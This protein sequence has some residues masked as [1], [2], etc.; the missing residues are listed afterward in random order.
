[1][2]TENQMQKV[3]G[4]DVYG[5]DGAKIG[6]AGTVY[7]DD[8][9]GRPEWVTVHTGLLGTKET[10]VPISEAEVRDNRVTVPYS[11]EQ[12]K[13]APSVDPDDGRH[14]SPK[15]EQRLYD[16]YGLRY[17]GRQTDTGR[18][19]GTVGRDTSGAETDEAMTRSEE[20]L[21]VGTRQ[22][23]AG[24]ARLRKYVV[25][26]EQNVQVPV[27]REEVR[28]ER[29]P[30]TDRNRGAA[31]NGPDISEEEHEV[32]LHEERP[33]VEK[34]AVPLERVRL[35]KE[36]VTRQETVR[37]EVRKEQIETEGLDENR[38]R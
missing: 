15:E 8:D 13:G 12:V 22:E 7:L 16:H 33:V 1:M 37:G 30:I 23:E 19:R 29:E 9:T 3:P 38:N 4:A 36:R 20:R 35:G 26:E 6:R 14:L 24:R 32:T 17:S 10:F 34:E 31:M 18:R 28:V 25:T 2:I 27:S 11:K 5:A 21:N